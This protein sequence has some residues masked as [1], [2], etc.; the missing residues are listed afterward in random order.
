MTYDR[1]DSSLFRNPYMSMN[2]PMRMVDERDGSLRGISELPPALRSKVVVQCIFPSL[3]HERLVFA[4]FRG[5]SY[6]GGC[7]AVRIP[8][9]I[10]VKLSY[11][12]MLCP[13][14][15]SHTP[16]SHTCSSICGDFPAVA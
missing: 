1:L 3:P 7:D 8:R 10:L 14:A 6:E 9:G 2:L 5:V 12:V 13:G 15:A 16:L 4:V 11:Y